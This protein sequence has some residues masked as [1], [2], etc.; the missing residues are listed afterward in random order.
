MQR[1]RVRESDVPRKLV[2]RVVANPMFQFWS[3]TLQMELEITL[4]AGKTD[5]AR[6]KM[7]THVLTDEEIAEINEAFNM[8]DK[9]G[10]GKITTKE[11][12]EVMRSLGRDP[13]DA[14]LEDMISEVDIDD[15]E[16][17]TK[18]GDVLV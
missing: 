2:Y 3:I 5:I 9:D 1:E 7:A 12:G 8:F 11:L 6:D 14:E 17:K 10:N 13:T 15:L 18:H 4:T 16:D